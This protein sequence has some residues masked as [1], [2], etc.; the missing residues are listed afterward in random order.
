MLEL[1]VFALFVFAYSGLAGGIS[2]TPISG[3]IVF[4]LFGYI[5]STHVPGILELDVTNER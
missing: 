3:A 5:A 2:R 4:T 1:T